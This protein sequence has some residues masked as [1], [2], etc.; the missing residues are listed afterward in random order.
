MRT[1]TQPGR[2]DLTNFGQL[3]YN[4]SDMEAELPPNVRMVGE[5]GLFYTVITIENIPKV[6][7]HCVFFVCVNS[8]ST[9]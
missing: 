5:E 1:P 8:L 4:F 3:N 6:D 9:L 7:L 2:F